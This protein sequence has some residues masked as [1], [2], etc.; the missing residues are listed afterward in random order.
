MTTSERGLPGM[1]TG[2]TS[3]T[4]N[5][6]ASHWVSPSF[7][8]PV[9]EDSSWETNVATLRSRRKST[10]SSTIYE[11]VVRVLEFLNE[12]FGPV[13]SGHPSSCVAAAA[14]EP[15]RSRSL[16]PVSRCATRSTHQYG[17][18]R[19]KQGTLPHLVAFPALRDSFTFVP[20]LLCRPRNAQ[21]WADS[22]RPRL[23][24]DAQAFGYHPRRRRIS[25]E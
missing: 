10:K 15:S 6:P 24:M 25:D 22:T 13:R 18:D 23:W 19:A 16:R 9:I 3:F 20:S 21:S 2:G 12:S 17:F 7:F 1:S 8:L 14:K 4:E 5:A 11:L